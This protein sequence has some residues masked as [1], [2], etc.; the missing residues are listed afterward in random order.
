MEKNLD[1]NEDQDLNDQPNQEINDFENQENSSE[2]E[3]QT[4][5]EE[6]KGVRS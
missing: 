5:D 1:E 2:I 6:K 4:L 3:D